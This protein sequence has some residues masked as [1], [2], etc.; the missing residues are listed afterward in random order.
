[1]IDLEE[2]F[3][4]QLRNKHERVT[5]AR[6]AIFETLRRKGL[7]S[8]A[9]LVQQMHKK[10]IDPATTYRNIALFRQLNII[11]DVGTGNRHMIEL[12]DE[13]KAHHHHFWCRK[14]HTYFDF[15][16]DAVEKS[17]GTI[18]RSLEVEIT[19]HHLELSGLCKHCRTVN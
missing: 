15:D 13:Y 8:T 12:S 10:A 3:K 18:A 5:S 14:C 2:Q 7:I 11:R 6:V 16:N 17:L 9:Q 1:M 4:I 19:S